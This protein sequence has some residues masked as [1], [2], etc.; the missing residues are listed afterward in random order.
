MTEALNG[1]PDSWFAVPE[2]LHAI[3]ANGYTAYL[4]PGSEQV[5]QAQ[6]PPAPSGGGGGDSHGHRKKH[7]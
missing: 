5:G 7:G 6:Q 3:N 4:L 2:G 1:Q